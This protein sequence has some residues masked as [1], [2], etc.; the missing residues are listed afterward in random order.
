MQDRKISVGRNVHLRHIYAAIEV[1][2]ATTA[3]LP[4]QGYYRFCTTFV[5]YQHFVLGHAC[6]CT[7]TSALEAETGQAL[8]AFARF[9]TTPLQ[10]AAPLGQEQLDLY[11][12]DNTI[13]V[14]T[15]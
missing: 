8:Q 12:A 5:L 14:D 3:V 11:L 1:K 4:W 6:T 10:T 13:C 2:S 7:T 9:S 15:F